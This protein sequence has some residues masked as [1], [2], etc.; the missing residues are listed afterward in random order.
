MFSGK[1]YKWNKYFMKQERQL[2]IT[3]QNVY[4][5]AKKSKSTLS[6]PATATS[7]ESH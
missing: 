6:A 4:N 5:F 3:N 1:V 7:P 2:V